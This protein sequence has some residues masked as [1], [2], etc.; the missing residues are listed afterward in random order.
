MLMKHF[1]RIFEGLAA[2]TVHATVQAPGGLAVIETWPDA[3]HNYFPW[4]LPHPSIESFKVFL[5]P[6]VRIGR[7]AMAHVYP[8]IE[9]IEVVRIL[10]RRLI[11]VDQ[12]RRVLPLIHSFADTVPI[13]TATFRENENDRTSLIRD[14]GVARGRLRSDVIAIGLIE[15]LERIV[16]GGP[17]VLGHF[18]VHQANFEVVFCRDAL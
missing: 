13:R 14:V 10:R 12:N 15:G 2:A 18:V 6:V 7:R 5:T 4:A 8:R 3:A 17:V 1:E 9:A 11:F 16:R